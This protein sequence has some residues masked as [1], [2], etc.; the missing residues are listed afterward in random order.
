MKTPLYLI[1]GAVVLI[2]AGA[3]FLYVSKRI[4]EPRC[5]AFL[6]SVQS[7]EQDIASRHDELTTRSRDTRARIEDT[8]RKASELQE[9][10]GAVAAAL[11]RNTQRLESTKSK[12]EKIRPSETML[13][14]RVQDA[15]DQAD[16]LRA[17]LQ[18]A[19]GT[20][21]AL[22]AEVDSLSNELTAIDKEL[23]FTSGEAAK[24]ATERTEWEH[25]ETFESLPRASLQGMVGWYGDSLCGGVDTSLWLLRPWN[26][27][28]GF[29][30]AYLVEE[31]HRT[32]FGYVGVAWQKLLSRRTNLDVWAGPY[33]A[34][35]LGRVSNPVNP[36]LGASLGIAVPKVHLG[37]GLAAMVTPDQTFVGLTAGYS[38]VGE[39]IDVYKRK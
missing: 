23:V 28:L 18:K 3:P 19:R 25:K 6:A 4:Y 37:L 7:R 24:L 9:K 39:A 5:A 30:G 36:A 34:P 1:W 16:T 29:K 17:Q 27:R 38:Q 26:Q 11:D 8:S 31:A 20:Q 14:G 32:D 21:V 13:A 33:W 2:A 22:T 35:R 15:E 10:T 12:L